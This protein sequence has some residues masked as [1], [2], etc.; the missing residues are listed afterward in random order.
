MPPPIPVE[1]REHNPSWAD[2]AREEATRLT[3]A[4]GEVMIVVHHIGSTAIP[5]IQAKP[6]LD[7]M[8]IVVSH[9]EFEKSRS[10]V[11]RLGYAWWGE[12]GL[13]GRR[14]CSLDDPLTGHR[15]VQLHCYERDSPEIARHLAFREYLKTH[16]DL[17]R[18]YEAEKCR[19]Q[20]LHPFDA[21]AYTECKNAW[22]RRIEAAALL[23]VGFVNR[24]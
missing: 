9:A 5:Y 4:V 11:E 22:I 7:L 15:T 6:I 20:T 18:E 3:T 16:R 23:S 10:T 12:H 21:H 8:P 17:A 19:C 14:Y 1:L 24:T 13:S 2:K